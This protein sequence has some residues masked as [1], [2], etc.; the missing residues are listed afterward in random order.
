MNKQEVMKM[1]TWVLKVNIQCS[2]DGCKQKIK[3]LLQKIDGVYTTSINA[4]QGKV[5]VTGNVDPAILIR[6][7]ERSGKRAQLWGSA[8][9]GSNNFQNQMTNQFKNMHFDGGK[10]NRSQKGG[11]GGKNK[12]QKGGQQFAPPP[13]LMQ[14]MMMKGSKDFK[15]PPS[16]DQKSAKFHLPDGDLDESDCDYDEFG[17]EE[18]DEGGFG[19]GHG[20]GHQMQ[21]KMVPMMG[22]G[23]GSY[24]PNGTVNGPP[25]NGKKGGGGKKRDAFDIPIVMKGMGENKD[26]KHGNGG[27]KGGGE[28]NKG[29]KQGGGK[30]GGGGLLGFFKK[31]KGA[32]DCNHKRGKNEW[33]GKNKGAYKG[34]RGSNGGGNNN[35]NGAKKGGTGMS[36]EMNKVKNGGFHDIDVIDHGKGGVSKKNMGQM[37]YNVGQMGRMGNYP[38]NQ[39]GNFPAV[40]GLPAAA[41]AAMNGFGGGY[42]QGMGPANP[43]QQQQQQQYMAMMMNQQRAN[44]N[45]GALYQPMMYAQ[46]QPYP[47]PHAPYGP[48]HPMHATA[49]NSESYA[50]FFSDENANACSIM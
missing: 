34:N 42:Y 40:Q 18:F 38:M 19:H 47:P 48:P 39:M 28:K 45:G 29:G 21:N 25:M 27:K 11:G 41:G 5:T 4:D 37:G 15:L 8:P 43:Y 46:A 14:Q 23:H 13:H 3:K 20:H 2:C 49:P 9:K 17:D 35:G 24:G 44:G 6:K 10:D 26:G 1:Q 30:K 16:K 7:L 33:D 32:N 50:H 31:D 12:Q 36:H 22:K